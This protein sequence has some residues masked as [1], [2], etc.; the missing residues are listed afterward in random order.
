MDKRI[1]AA[2][3]LAAC[4]GLPGAAPAQ[5][6]N[7]PLIDR[8]ARLER[9]LNSDTLIQ[10]LQRLERLQK[11]VQE[12]RGELEV[13]THDLAQLKQRQRDLYLDMDRRL[14]EAQAAP[15]QGPAPVA[16]ATGGQAAPVQPAQ[17]GGTATSEPSAGGAAPPPVPAASAA[18]PGASEVDPIKEQDA[19]QTA[20]NL[21]K[22]GRYDQAGTAFDGF[23]REYP[24]GKYS[25]NA[26]YWLGEAYYVTR[27]F[28]PAMGEFKKLLADFPESPKLTH[29]LL[30]IGYIYDELGQCAEAEKS[31]ND[32]VAR[33]PQTTAARLA[34]ER[35][36]RMR[37][38]S[39]P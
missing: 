22:A 10:L 6:S 37:T 35:L 33:F 2:W 14:R 29:A 12:L 20:F 11:E 9:L 16:A 23:L 3:V 34:R 39:C 26:Q 27:Q 4:I 8:V 5:T 1:L 28:E 24:K 25:D 32:L 36:Q 18:A 17:T 15:A 13:Q 7:A 30:K 21:L 38:G 31:L 19:Y